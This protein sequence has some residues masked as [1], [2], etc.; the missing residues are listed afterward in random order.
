MITKAGVAYLL[1]RLC[2]VNYVSGRSFFSATKADC[3]KLWK[4]FQVWTNTFFG[5]Q[6][7]AFITCKRVKPSGL[8]ALGSL[9]F[10]LAVVKFLC[11]LP[12]VSGGAMAVCVQLDLSLGSAFATGMARVLEQ[13][14]IV[15]LI[16]IGFFERNKSFHVCRHLETESSSLQRTSLSE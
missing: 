15:V 13:I 5:L 10:Y 16:V 14:I 7:D 6:R 11:Y 12:L 9:A 1:S 3:S 2:N 4:I 8:R